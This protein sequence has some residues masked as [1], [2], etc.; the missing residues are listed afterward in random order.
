MDGEGRPPGRRVDGGVLA[1]RRRRGQ[2]HAGDH[3]G[4]RE[5]PPGPA[6]PRSAVLGVS[7]GEGHVLG[8]GPLRG[9]LHAGPGGRRGGGRFLPPGGRQLG[10]VR[11][12]AAAHRSA[13]LQDPGAVLQPRPAGQRA[14]GEGELRQV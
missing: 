10:G 1:V 2:A 9:L 7:G 11:R 5:G 14:A 3:G 6:V 13:A 4:Q 8:E 12:D